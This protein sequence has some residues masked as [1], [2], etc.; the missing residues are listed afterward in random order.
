M[1]VGPL[2]GDLQFRNINAYA[3]IYCNLSN[4]NNLG[5]ILTNWKPQKY[6][7]NSQWDTYTIA[8]EI[9]KN[10]GNYN[11]MDALPAF[12][13]TH[14]DAT[15]DANWEKIYRVAYEKAPQSFCAQNDISKFLPWSGDEDI[16]DIVRKNMPVENPF[17]EIKSFT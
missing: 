13:K 14:F 8:A 11:Y 9:L 3:E 10:K 15:W 12:I 5:I 1:Q 6:I 7:Q 4:P 2:V 17:S 16:K